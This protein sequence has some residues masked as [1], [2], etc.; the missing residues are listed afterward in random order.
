[1]PVQ[2]RAIQEEERRGRRKN[3]RRRKEFLEK[4]AENKDAKSNISSEG[5]DAKE[6]EE[7]TSSAAA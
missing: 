3:K 6:S 2:T 5:S 1:M 4:K 7:V